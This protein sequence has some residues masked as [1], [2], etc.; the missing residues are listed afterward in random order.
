MEFQLL[1]TDL[2][3]ARLFR[4]SRSFG[5][6][7]AR[8]IANMLYLETMLTYMLAQ[9]QDTSE[10]AR[11][12]AK[13]TIQFGTYSLFRTHATDLYMLCYQVLYPN[14]DYAK[15]KD[16]VEGKRFLKNLNFNKQMHTRFVRKIAQ[17]QDERGEAVTYLYRLEKQME[18][19]DGRYRGWRRMITNWTNLKYSSKQRVVAQIIQEL[20]RTGSGSGQYTELMKIIAPMLKQPKFKN[21]P[22]VAPKEQPSDTAKQVASAGLGAIAGFWAGRKKK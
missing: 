21:L 12:Y 16:P 5:A 14:N 3:E 1:D 20:R 6:L 19:T 10:E 11:E 13:K 22:K 8:E 4:A 2:C 9:N 7:T 18:V 15:I 17:S